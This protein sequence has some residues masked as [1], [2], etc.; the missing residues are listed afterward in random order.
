MPDLTTGA[1]QKLPTVPTV[2]TPP[3]KNDTAA[4]EAQTLFVSADRMRDDYDETG[5]DAAVITVEDEGF[6]VYSA[7]DLSVRTESPADTQ[8]DAAQTSGEALAPV[9]VKE[10]KVYHAGWFSAGVSLLFAGVSLAVALNYPGYL[11]TVLRW[12]PVVLVLLGL[13]LLI[14]AIARRKIKISVA[15]WIACSLVIALSYGLAAAALNLTNADSTVKTSE[16]AIERRV[17]AE[18]LNSLSADLSKFDE[19]V[20]LQ[21]EFTLFGDLADYHSYEDLQETDVVDLSFELSLKENTPRAMA[22]T[23][24]RILAA[25]LTRNERFGNIYFT[26]ENG[27]NIL[28]LSVDARF[29]MQLAQDDLLPMVVYFLSNDA[30]DLTDIVEE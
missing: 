30:E 27:F 11:L 28:R 12:S 8:Q 2:N 3:E 17:H 22:Q 10:K 29:G 18:L 23:A 16:T 14:G 25:L 7:D 4:P 6:E 5:A 24:G 13:E 21:A 9:T 20:A 19:I 1:L 15:S 26:S